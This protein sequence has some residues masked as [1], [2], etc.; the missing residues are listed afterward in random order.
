MSFNFDD[1]EIL[2]VDAWDVIAFEERF[3]ESMEELFHFD[4]VNIVETDAQ[5]YVDNTKK[6]QYFFLLPSL[7]QDSIRD[8]LK[9]W[10]LCDH[11][12]LKHWCKKCGAHTYRN[13]YSNKE[14]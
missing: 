7:A 11:L 14:M 13:L 10:L 1:A 3:G 2:T 8:S 6:S 9:R 12:E 4:G 5:L